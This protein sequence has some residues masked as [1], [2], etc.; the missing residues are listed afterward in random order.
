M[1]E[2]TPEAMLGKAIPEA[3][4]LAAVE[5]TT[6]GFRPHEQ[7]D[8][9]RAWHG[10]IFDGSR[11]A[12]V[13]DGYPV[14]AR[15]VALD[16]L[17]L[18]RGKTPAVRIV[19]TPALIRRNPIDHWALVM[20]F[21]GPTRLTIC[22]ETVQAPARV[23]FLHSLADE[24]V[25]ERAPDERIQLYL[26]RDSFRDLAPI[27]DG[28]RG[29][30]TGPGATLL[31]E[32]LELL[33]RNLATLDV[34]S[35]PRLKDAIGAMIAACVSPGPDRLAAAARP[36][37][38]GRMERIRRAVRQHL[39]SPAMSTDV[40]C[41]LVGMSR[42]ALYR[43]MESQGGVAGYIRRQR[44]LESRAVLSDPD[45]D[46][47]IA[48]IAEDFC[49]SDSANFSRAFRREFG[50]TPSEARWAAKAGLVAP[51]KAGRDGGSGCATLDDVLRTL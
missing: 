26:A 7:Y 21:H 46:R 39:R 50:L 14:E 51:A 2:R 6:R 4:R 5:F 33:G 3:P 17:A 45:C 43:L 19:R 34:A 32:F 42:S 38:F 40:L 47:P 48:A 31:A 37:D 29:V 12:E 8:A 49:F 20:A 10:E 13:E 15:S 1:V 24:V 23:P 41:R 25:S 36:L 28:A 18:V 22:R 11:G 35:A 30:V 27:L 44:L 16:G 9:F